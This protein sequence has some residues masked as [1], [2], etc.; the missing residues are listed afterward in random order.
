MRDSIPDYQVA[1]WL[2]AVYFKG[3][4]EEETQVLTEL[5]WKSGVSLPRPHREGFWVDKHSTGGVGDK[6]SLILV[7]LVTAAC[8]RL[9][10]KGQ[11][12]I[13]MISGRG[14]GHT[15]GT[16][17]KLE[18]VSGFSPRIEL[19][20]ALPLLE[21]NGYFMMGQTKDLAPADRRLYAL[22]DTTGT[23]ESIPLIVS[24]IMSKKLS[25]SLDGLVLDLKWGAGA[26][27]DTAEKAKVLGKAL[28]GVAKRCGVQAQGILTSMQEPMGWS[29]GHQ[30]EVEECYRY[31]QGDNREEGMHAVVLA[32]GSAMVQLAG[33]GKVSSAEARSACEEELKASGVNA[34]FREMF[35]AQ[36][37]DFN[38][39]EKGVGKVASST[40]VSVLESPATGYVERIQPRLLGEYLGALGGGRSKVD[41]K[42]DFSVGAILRKKVGDPVQK[43]EEL[44]RVHA[45]SQGK[46][47]ERPGDLYVISPTPV[48]K[49]CW[50]GETLT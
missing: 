1:A 32:L 8:E 31:L 43:G 16:L 35:E 46:K 25:E 3:L 26:F 37:G 45:S 4:S 14:L 42:I 39:W 36:G 2:M 11:V 7:P 17:D 30:L 49:T 19:D 47:A 21:K 24:S 23:V 48:E 15:G 18:T 41:D 27:M 6:T 28:V 22:R 5:M 34:I 29:V 38:T 10:G 13:P 33:R 20:K 12:K 50:V 40:L 44:M 9:Y